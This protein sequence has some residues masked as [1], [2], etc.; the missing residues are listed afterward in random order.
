MNKLEGDELGVERDEG[1]ERTLS[2]PYPAGELVW[3]TRH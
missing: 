3:G 1:D 2:H